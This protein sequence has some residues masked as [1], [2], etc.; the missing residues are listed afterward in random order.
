MPA[1]ACA[2]AGTRATRR[3]PARSHPSLPLSA[4]GQRRVSARKKSGVS[5]NMSDPLESFGWNTVLEQASR[6]H[7]ER[8]L[9]PARVA[10]ANRDSWSLIVAEG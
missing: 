10:E 1:D 8:G 7:R 3:G 6:E 9:L 4:E 5:Q 2:P